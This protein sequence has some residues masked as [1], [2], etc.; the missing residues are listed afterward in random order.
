MRSRSR[1]ECC[2]VIANC[3]YASAAVGISSR[4]GRRLHTPMRSATIAYP[5]NEAS[6]SADGIN[7][8]PDARTTVHDADS[9]PL[10]LIKWNLGRC[11]ARRILHRG[12]P[13]EGDGQ[14]QLVTQGRTAGVGLAPGCRP[15]RVGA[16]SFSPQG[17][18]NCSGCGGRE[19]S[20]L[21]GKSSR[22]EKKKRCRNRVSQAIHVAQRDPR[23]HAARWAEYPRASEDF[24]G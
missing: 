19:L 13:I 23:G 5:F 24:H 4:L 22:G 7:H 9:V 15:T 10:L 12:M 17:G 18:R 2:A 21:R 6:T 16:E 8:T 1:L 3:R 14:R 11:S 20:R